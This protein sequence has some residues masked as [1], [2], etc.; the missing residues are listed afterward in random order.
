M[1]TYAKL[2]WIKVFEKSAIKVDE[3]AL[4]EYE[5]LKQNDLCYSIKLNTFSDDTVTIFVHNVI[6]LWRY[7]DDIVSNDRIIDN[8]IKEFTETQIHPSGSTCK[9]TE[10]LNF[11]NININN[12]ENKF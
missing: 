7:I 2:Y 4:L 1:K 12:N 9:V 11:F 3:D 10:R 6:S 5:R 8:D